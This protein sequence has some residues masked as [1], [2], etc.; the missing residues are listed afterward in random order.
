M[1]GGE[2]LKVASERE[3]V[4]DS[5]EGI[6]TCCSFTCVLAVT[7]VDFV[8]IDVVDESLV[9]GLGSIFELLFFLGASCSMNFEFAVSPFRRGRGPSP[10]VSRSDSLAIALI[11]LLLSSFLL[12]T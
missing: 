6:M 5:R 9:G 8:L 12:R 3:E 4:G 2:P 10:E 7:G 11:E 1:S